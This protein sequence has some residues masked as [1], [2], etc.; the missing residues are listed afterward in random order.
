MKPHATESTLP[1]GLRQDDDEENGSESHA[2][3]SPSSSITSPSPQQ[4]SV[5]TTARPINSNKRKRALSNTSDNGMIQCSEA[6][7]SISKRQ[8]VTKRY[9]YIPYV[10]LVF[11]GLVECHF[12]ILPGVEYERWEEVKGK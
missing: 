9:K 1:L 2:S 5:V 8:K 4:Q 3:A 7:S 10:S 11:Q 6:L 12:R